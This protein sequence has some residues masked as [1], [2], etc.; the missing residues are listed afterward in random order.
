MASAP[1]ISLLANNNADPL[2]L[3]KASLFQATLQLMHRDFYCKRRLGVS[4]TL[5]FFY[6][7][8][9]KQKIPPKVLHTLFPSSFGESAT[10]PTEA[11]RRMLN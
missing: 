9:S 5:K 4:S 8:Q 7:Q 1:S 10:Q 11:K 6:L 3:L 2:P